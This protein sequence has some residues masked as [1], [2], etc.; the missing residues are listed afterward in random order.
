MGEFLSEEIGLF[1][2]IERRVRYAGRH[3]D[4]TCLVFDVP[5]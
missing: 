5:S 3:R 1:E 4:E 2:L